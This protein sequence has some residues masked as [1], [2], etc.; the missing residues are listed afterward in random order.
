MFRRNLFSI[1]LLSISVNAVALESFDERVTLAKAAEIDDQLKA[2]LPA[3]YGA[4]GPQV[5]STMRTC[6][7]RTE[8]GDKSPF[9][10]IADISPAGA[11][12]NIEVKPTTNVAQC[13][14]RGFSTITFPSPPASAKRAAFPVMIEMR[15]S[16]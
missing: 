3:M 16:K 12:Q 2:Y 15:I 7:D 14:A 10:L 6:F 8:G 11:A 4:V 9:V 5:A 13:F 1:L